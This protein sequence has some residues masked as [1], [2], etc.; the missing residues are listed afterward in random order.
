MLYSLEENKP[1]FDG[2]NFVAPDASL[3]GKVHLHKGASVWF[4][5]V[6]RGDNEFITI[7]ENSNIQDGT[8]CHT[9]MG[10]PLT[11]GQGV[12]VGHNVILHG[13]IIADNVLV[14]MGSTVM[15]HVKVGKNTIIGANSVLTEGKEFPEGVL[16]LG[17]PARVK[18]DLSAEEISL[19]GMSCEIYVKNAQRYLAHLKEYN[20]AVETGK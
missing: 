2:H 6:L 19:I 18:R 9:D 16:I 20:N 4:K 8:V 13:C 15:N 5:S 1:Q 7:G 17:A 11:L 3:I 14:G 12:T 10:A